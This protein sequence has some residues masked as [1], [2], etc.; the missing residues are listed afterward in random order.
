MELL[1]KRS[2]AGLDAQGRHYV[3]MVLEA[4]AR[5]EQLIEDLLSF[6]RMS[7]RDLAR[8]PVALAS[9]VHELIEELEPDTRDRTVCWSVGELRVV[10]GDRAMLRCVLFEI[11]CETHP[12]E[13][14]CYVRDNGVGF[15]QEFAD[16]L[17]GVFQRLHH[18]EE[19][20]GTGIG[21]AT[22]R[23]IVHRHGGRTWATGEVGRGATFYFS[24]PDE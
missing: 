19:F 12:H 16:H 21:L 2:S 3:Q 6:S 14:H 24:L 5:M 10:M 18:A 4:A 11:G 8:C 9:I 1:R 17:F 7:R 15:A 13:V 23:R 20:E 22:V